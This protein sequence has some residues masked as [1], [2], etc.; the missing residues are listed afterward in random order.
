MKCVCGLSN[1]EISN[2]LDAWNNGELESFL[3]EISRDILKFKDTD[4]S[5]LV[6]KILDSASQKGTGKWTGRAG[7]DQGI[8]ITLIVEAVFARSLSSL[9]Q[10]R[11]T[12]SAKLQGPKP[13]LS[14]E[15]KKA[16]SEF[17]SA[18]KNALY[19]SK[20]IS[21]AQGFMLMRAASQELN[22][23]LNMGG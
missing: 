14:E 3:I 1:D 15:Y 22:W 9:K 16:P 18:V 8:P 6:D 21:Y 2:V 4:G 7:L 13:L 12:A 17:L 11:V 20:I 5:S 19:A 23:D 10:E